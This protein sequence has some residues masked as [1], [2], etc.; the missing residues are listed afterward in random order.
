MSVLLRRVIAQTKVGFELAKAFATTL[1][2]GNGTSQDVISNL[3]FVAKEGLVWIKNRDSVGR[4]HYLTDT[5]R[6]AT[7]TLLSN[8]TSAEFSNAQGLTTFNA[9]GF[10][11]GNHVSVNE[12]LDGLVAW[13]FIEAAGFFDIVEYVGDGVAGRTVAL[14]LDD[15]TAV[16]GMSIV[17]SL[18]NGTHDWFVQHR[19]LGGTKYLNL[20]DTGAETT[21]GTIWEN[22][23]ATPTLLTLGVNAQ[24][25]GNT[26]RFISYNFAHNPTKGIFCGIYVGTGAAGNKQTTTFPV[27]WVV[28]KRSSDVSD[29]DI[30][31]VTRSGGSTLNK[32]LSANTTAAESTFAA[33]NS[34]SDG[35]DFTGGSF[36][37][38]GSTYIFMAIADPAQF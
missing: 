37:V 26:V 5:V 8:G 25:N 35:F 6:G 1:Y 21:S 34:L 24:L 20:N 9:D 3:D 10:S 33:I 2:T 17:K 29:W 23:D 30:Y 15:G 28:I 32:N 22:T 31:D 13:Q 16:F 27:G 14:D 19:S 38:A 7:N 11:V 36:N 4:D 18:D 12:S